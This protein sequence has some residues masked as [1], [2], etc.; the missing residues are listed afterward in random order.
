V[1]K[2]F[3]RE[4]GSKKGGGESSVEGQEEYRGKSNPKGAKSLQGE[5]VENSR[6]RD[7]EGK[8]KY[9]NLRPKKGVRVSRK[10]NRLGGR[11]FRGR[12]KTNKR[13]VHVPKNKNFPA[14]GVPGTKLGGRNPEN[15]GKRGK[16]GGG[17]ERTQGKFMISGRPPSGK[18]GGQ[19]RKG[20]GKK[21]RRRE[22]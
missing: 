7:R 3:D 14:K 2:R 19:E 13:L 20:R 12:R 16:L 22:A 4:G 10:E 8:A 18:G 17:R 21:P 15:H 6:R 11:K 5:E 1:G 9:K